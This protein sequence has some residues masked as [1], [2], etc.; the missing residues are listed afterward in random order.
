MKIRPM[1]LN[2]SIQCYLFFICFF[3]IIVIRQLNP[4]FWKTWLWWKNTIKTCDIN[5]K[6]YYI[7]NDMTLLF[8]CSFFE[9]LIYVV[10]IISRKNKSI[11]NEILENTKKRSYYI[12]YIINL[13]CNIWSNLQGRNRNKNTQTWG[14]TEVGAGVWG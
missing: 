11:A 4:L 1:K 12:I 5:W 2:K 13:F 10:T 3:R 7:T 6:W 8:L 14:R 9:S